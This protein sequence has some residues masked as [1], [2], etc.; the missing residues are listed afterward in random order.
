MLDIFFENE[1]SDLFSYNAI[2][3]LVDDQL[4]LDKTSVSIDQKYHGIISKV[5][6]DKNKF[7]GKFGQTIA[8]TLIDKDGNINYLIILGTGD[9]KKLTS[10][11][12]EELGGKIYS[13]SCA[14]KAPKVCYKSDYSIADFSQ[15]RI[16]TL[17]ASGALL[18]SYKFDKYFT[19]KTEQE[20][21][22]TQ[23]LTVLVK[24]PDKIYK[25]FEP[26]KAIAMGVHFARNL[27]SE[28]PNILYPETYA[29]KI[30]E[31]LESIGVDVNVLGERELRDL[32]MGAMLGV[33]QGST[34]ESKLVVMEYYGGDKNQKPICLIGK[35]V[36]FDTGGISIKPAAGMHEMKYDMGG[37]AAVVGT[38]K[39]LALR[40]AKIN[41][42][43]IVGLVENM[44]DGAAQRPG[45]VV[46]TMSGMTVEVL[47][48]DA[49]GRLVL[50][51]CI[52]YAQEKFDPECIID[53][54][55][56]TGVI[57]ISLG[58]TYAGLFSNDDDIANKLLNSS[59]KTNEKLWRMPLHKEYDKMIDSSVA[60]IAN[61]GSEKGIAG[62]ATA[63]QFL[64]R[65]VKEGIK[66]A[67]LDIAG[68]AWDRSGTNP[69]CPKG[70]AGFGVRLLNNF[71]EE[72]YESK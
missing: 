13:T 42:V 34:N 19:K 58:H 20:K 32:Q 6:N 53:L 59:V 69:I 24:S 5:I 55:T 28:V 22:V 50:C 67:H 39:A 38:I 45:D 15:E 31:K 68:V 47:N 44:P 27:I 8:L 43:G 10:F 72:N 41:V 14:L 16:S 49:E 25:E 54:A 29:E 36:T 48:T 26:Y 52:T 65:F 66:W 51:D 2:A 30:V 71:I 3:I 17:L 57:V 11:Q 62:S 61:I 40:G 12:I 4:K 33:G 9:S 23:S 21:F 46:K 64:A 63:A 60:D 7:E 35:G 70:A 18:A 1:N 56:L 37:S